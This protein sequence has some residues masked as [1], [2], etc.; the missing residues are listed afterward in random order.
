MMENQNKN[1]QKIWNLQ[2]KHF[3]EILFE[4]MTTLVSF[5]YT[6]L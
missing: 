1:K 5:K 6:E 4:K 3:N 2:I